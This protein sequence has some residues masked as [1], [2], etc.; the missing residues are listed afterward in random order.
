MKSQ[1]EEKKY[2]AYYTDKKTGK[3]FNGYVIMFSP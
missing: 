2:N 1:K 3:V